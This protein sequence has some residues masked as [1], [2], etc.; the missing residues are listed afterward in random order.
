MWW[1]GQPRSRSSRGREVLAP[2]DLVLLP[3]FAG[4]KHAVFIGIIPELPGI[5]LGD[6]HVIMLFLVAGGDL[7]THICAEDDEKYVKVWP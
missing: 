3:T 2:G 1:P 5:T 7:Q 6:T 4:V